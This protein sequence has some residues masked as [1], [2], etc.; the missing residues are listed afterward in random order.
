VENLRLHY[1]LTLGAWLRRYERHEDQVR[2]MYDERFA[3][4]WRLYLAGSRTA[5][6]IGELQ[7]FQLVFSQDH[8]NDLPWSRAH[9]YPGQ[10]SLHAVE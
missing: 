8:N 9:Q 6:N 2:Q 7:L 10:A 1:A 4:T 3:R 5:F